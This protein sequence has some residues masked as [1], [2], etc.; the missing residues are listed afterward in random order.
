[1]NHRLQDL[2]DAL[3]ERKLDGLL[4]STPENRRYLSGFTGSAGYLLVTQQEAVLAT[5]FRYVEQAGQQ[6][7]DFRVSRIGGSF[8]WLPQ[9]LAETGVSKVAFESENVSVALHRRMTQTLKEST[10]ITSGKPRL[11]ATDGIVEE[12]RTL[13]DQEEMRL[14]QRAIDIADRAMDTVVPTIRAG[15]TEQ[16]V[17]WRLEVAMRELGAEGPS[18]D[19]IVGAGPNGALPH[20]RAGER[21]IQEGEPIVIDMGAKYQG[22]CSDLTRTVILGQPDDTFRRVYDTV[23]GAQLT[24]IATVQAGMTGADADGLAR[25]V[26]EEAGYGDH[27]GHSLGHGVGLAVHEFPRVGP[28]AQGVLREG[29]VFTIEPGIYLTGWGGV[30]IEDVV[31]MEKAGARALSKARKRDRTGG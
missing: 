24:A 10:A 19:T 6:A 4:V 3:K 18:F 30:R 28:A 31:A 12:L 8:D 15:Q 16:E 21:P 5:D 9:L 17:A 20:H 26:I 11:L 25:K 22:Y 27:F 2:R 1:M 23:L 7:P 14:L 13:K 29:M